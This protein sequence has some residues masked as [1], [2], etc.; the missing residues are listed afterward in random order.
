MAWRLLVATGEM[1]WRLLVATG[2]MAW[3]LLRTR[4]A[5]RRWRQRQCLAHGGVEVCLHGAVPQTLTRCRVDQVVLDGPAGFGARLIRVQ[6]ALKRHVEPRQHA[7]PLP[8]GILGF[9]GMEERH[10][11][12]AAHTPRPQLVQLRIRVQRA[13][14][15]EVAVQRKTGHVPVP[16]QVRPRAVVLR[17]VSVA[18]VPVQRERHR[19]RQPCTRRTGQH[20]PKP[21]LRQ[22]HV[23]LVFSRLRHAILLVHQRQCR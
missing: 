22:A 7:V 3:R 6:F 12:H 19:P 18:R 10:V 11:P 16:H 15:Q 14:G 5:R 13:P 4:W 1:A 9:V 20:R 17:A 8:A 2:E 21:V 23:R